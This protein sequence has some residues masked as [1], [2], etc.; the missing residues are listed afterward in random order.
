MLLTS[1]VRFCYNLRMKKR[2][3]HSK[4]FGRDDE[5]AQLDDL[6]GR[7]GA[8][9][10]TCRG[11]RRIGKSTLVEEFA[12]RSGARFIKL[13]GLRP[14]PGMAESD[15][16]TFF[17]SKLAA[18]T[19]CEKTPPEDWYSAFLRLDR[20]IG[21]KG[22]TVVLMDE[23]SW[24]AQYSLTFPEVLKNAWDDHFKKHP[25][26]I[27]VLC[28]SV[29][30]WIRDSIVQNRAYVGR[31]SLDMVVGELPPAECLKFWGRKAARIDPR[32]VVDVLSVTGGVPRY[33]E[34]IN[35][36]LSAMENIRR[37]CF[38]PK[39]VLREDFDDM[40]NDVVTDQPRFS[41]RVLRTFVDGARTATEV[42]DELKITKGGDVSSAIENL[43]EAGFLSD[44]GRVN[45]ETG[46]ELR[47]RRFRL[48]DNYARFYLKC[49]EP[50]KRIIDD[51]AFEF[52]SLDEL[53]GYDSVMGLAFE[54]MV[55]NNYRHLIRLLHLEGLVITSAG[56]YMRRAGGGSR[57]RKGCQV[58]LLIQTRRTM[59]IVE[60]KRMREIG[61]E[62]I[63]EVDRKV[64]AIKRPHG[65][66]VRTALVYD[67]H[68]API[69]KA[70]GYFDA[71]VPFTS[72]LEMT[73]V[74][75]PSGGVKILV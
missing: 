43:V 75:A 59:C 60:V 68:V 58:D 47:E 4:F 31:R 3:R 42:A 18:Q 39:S 49:I 21:D 50:H 44:S 36:S 69:V 2:S 64:R 16:L 70:D 12:M 27:L 52:A 25:Q 41:A 38:T 72:L 32:E 26:L 37:L 46:G 48:R 54:N 56:P 10:V 20:E 61:R 24:M 74:A 8:S 6:W 9:L 13:E 33:L 62:I 15:Q 11:R 1:P 19:G 73:G 17:A 30:S 57:G 67:G 5:L 45:P 23:I 7:R 66:S 35:P 55:V 51:G 40:F 71:I 29:S 14:K 34:E 28:G 63:G 65:V 22:R 53:E